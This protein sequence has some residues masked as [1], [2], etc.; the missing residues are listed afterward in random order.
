MLNTYT[1]LHIH[2][3][4]AVKYRTAMIKEW[5]LL[6]HCDILRKSSERLGLA[7]FAG[8]TEQR[9]SAAVKGAE[10]SFNA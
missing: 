4:F 1:K 8:T 6:N 9:K 5:L 7:A 10:P 3:V 2:C